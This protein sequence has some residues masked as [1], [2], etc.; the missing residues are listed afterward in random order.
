[1]IYEL[2]Y[3]VTLDYLN[4]KNMQIKTYKSVWSVMVILLTVSFVTKCICNLI[5]NIFC[6]FTRI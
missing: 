4:T 3:F 1:M 2:D 6:N 5:K